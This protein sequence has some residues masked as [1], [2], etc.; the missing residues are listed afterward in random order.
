M[1]IN[2]LDILKQIFGGEFTTLASRFLGE[3]EANTKTA[4]TSMLPALLGAIVQKGSTPN[5]ASSLFSAIDNPQV[6]AS[7]AGNISRILGGGGNASSLVNT[8][9]GMLS[10]LLGPKASPLAGA[11][12]SMSGISGASATSLLSLALP[13]ILGALKK[14][15]GEHGL[16]AN[17]LT[18]LLGSQTKTLEG[19]LDPRLSQA[20]GIKLP[21]VG[22]AATAV[23]ETTSAGP[24]KVLPWIIAALV[25]LTAFWLYRSCSTD[26]AQKTAD[27]A[28]AAATTAVQTS[29]DAA[30]AAVAAIRSIDLPDGVKLD[31][32]Q[33]GFIDS[34][35]AFVSKPDW[36]S[37]KSFAFDALTFETDS[38][39]LTPASAAQLTQFATVL[40]AFPA[41]YVSVQGHTDNTGDPDANKKLSEDRA[42][43]VEAALVGMGMSPERVTSVGWGAEK[44]IASND[45]E[46]GKLQNRRVEIT[47]TKK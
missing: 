16:N 2:L 28:K 39:T 10:S 23:A 44:P 31:V 46:A 24:G 21:S 47:L 45:T 4:V 27:A 40:K 7:L 15:V 30:K 25:G 41:I 19:A 8:G 38:A 5:G 29:S 1:N 18:S 20:M 12:S 13:L 37:G 34:L 6:D 17:S 9:S 14:L 22:R 36:V 42:A 3:S 26:T 32:P 33:G 11:L 43:A 35:V